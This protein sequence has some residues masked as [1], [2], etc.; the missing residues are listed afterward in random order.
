MVSWI[1]RFGTHSYRKPTVYCFASICRWGMSWIIEI[2]ANLQF[3]T[4][5]LN[6]KK[7]LFDVCIDEYL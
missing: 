3:L 6:L 2:A 5:I 7:W 1:Y 4:I